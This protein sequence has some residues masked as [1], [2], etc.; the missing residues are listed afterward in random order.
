MSLSAD[1]AFLVVVAHQARVTYATHH[2]NGP[3]A[4]AQTHRVRMN[5]RPGNL[6]K[7]CVCQALRAGFFEVCPTIG[8]CTTASLNWS[9][10]AAMAKTPPS[11]SYKFCSVISST[12]SVRIQHQRVSAPSASS[13]RQLLQEYPGLS[14]IITLTPPIYPFVVRSS[15]ATL[16]FSRERIY[17]GNGMLV[18]RVNGSISLDL[19]VR[20]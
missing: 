14:N 10:T 2:W 12:S 19:Q 20:R 8:F 9:T 17:K 18:E 4:T 5:L 6:P 11:R 7:F 3:P 15:V 13:P 1:D 16:S